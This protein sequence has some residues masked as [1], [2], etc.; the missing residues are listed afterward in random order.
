MGYCSNSIASSL[1][2]F[3]LSKFFWTYRIYRT[4]R[5]CRIYGKYAHRIIQDIRTGYIREINR[6]Y[7]KCQKCRISRIYRIYRTHGLYWTYQIYGIILW[8]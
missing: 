7:R 3:I 2:E 4:K 5:I 6:I 8:T 1:W